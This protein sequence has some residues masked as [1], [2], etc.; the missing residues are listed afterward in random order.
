MVIQQC[1]FV[2][3]MNVLNIDFVFEFPFVRFYVKVITLMKLIYTT[4]DSFSGRETLYFRVVNGLIV[5]TC[6]II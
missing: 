5:V 1:P 4:L 2:I 6:Q 3:S